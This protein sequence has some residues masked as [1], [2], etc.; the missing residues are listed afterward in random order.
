MDAINA[1]KSG[2]SCR[3]QE[4]EVELVWSLKS[5]KRRIYWN[6]RN[7]SNNLFREIS[8]P[9]MVELSWRTETGEVLTVVAHSEPV[10]GKPQYDFL[11]DNVSFYSMPNV[12]ELSNVD[13]NEECSISMAD[14]DLRS[15]P[16]T[17]TQSEH[18][19]SS[20]SEF[21]SLRSLNDHPH[22]GMG[23]RLSMVGLSNGFAETDELRSEV[24]SPMLESLRERIVEFLPQTEGLISRSIIQ[25]FFPDYVSQHSEDILSCL[26][27]S[28]GS[29]EEREPQQIEV[30]ALYEAH[31]WAAY[32][33]ESSSP[34]EEEALDYMQKL[35]DSVFVKVRNEDISSDEGGR[36]LLGVAAVLRLD[37]KK[38][39]PKDTLLLDNLGADMTSED[40]HD[41]L[42]LYGDVEAVAIATRRSTFGFCRFMTEGALTRVL[43]ADKAGVFVLM[44]VHPRVVPLTEKMQATLSEPIARENI[45]SEVRSTV[46]VPTSVRKSSTS[47][48]PHLMGAWTDDDTDEDVVETMVVVTPD[49]NARCFSDDQEFSFRSQ[50]AISD[51]EDLLDAP[52]GY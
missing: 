41:A 16:P 29:S 4:H 26:S 51:F 52:G 28:K 7:V 18:L 43:E 20:G 46:P 45:K 2:S 9:D 47:S 44:G 23:F 42:R 40:V 12:V 3:G 33:A 13:L 24:Y 5:G 25:T 19:G 39:L 14:S 31:E 6:R 22:D 49:H 8:G 21:D 35:I 27:G 50:R 10:H 15:K 48:I 17:N 1:G 34:P 38:S 36:I 30:D 11:I 37:F 32:M